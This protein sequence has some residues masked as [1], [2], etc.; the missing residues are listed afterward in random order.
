MA[1][2]APDS[3][4]S[5][6]GRDKSLRGDRE[7]RLLDLRFYGEIAGVYDSGVTPAASSASGQPAG[8]AADYGIESGAGLSASRRWRHARLTVEYRGRF[9][10]Y[11]RSSPFNGSDQFLDLAY[12]QLLNRYWT[13]NL[14]EIA[15]TTTLANGAF[16]YLP[17]SSTD[18][19]AVPSN[20]LFDNRTN[21]LQSRVDLEWQKSLRLSL[22][23]DGEGF[24]VRRQ[25]LALAGL[26]GY[27]ARAGLAYRLTR[28]QTISATYQHIYFDFQRAFGDARIETAAL[29]YSVALTRRL[30]LALNFGGSRAGVMGLMPVVIAPEIAA[31]IGNNS[32]LVSFTRVLYVPLAEARLARSFTRSSLI[33][34]Y[35]R[36][37]TPGN[38]VYLTSRQTSGTV[39]FTY[40]G[41]HRVSTA[42]S[43]SYHQLSSIGQTLPAYTNLQGGGGLT[44]RLFRETYL[45]LRYDYRH[46]NTHD[47]LLQKDSNRISLG[48]AF[49]PGDAPLAIW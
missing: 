10:D 14:K 8:A 43:A 13:L 21:Y 27:G 32:A 7:G 12:S 20:D 22:D 11:A 48:L 40:T 38:G 47:L 49:S 6:L 35:S 30:D 1:E 29:G 5:V 34:D 45:A 18:L 39:A 46:Y 9:R 25:S 28:R 2:R 33:L 3:G 24:V 36:G 17:L 44:Y 37:I 41:A 42:L 26:N 16:T 4:P 31:I 15:G 19:Y 23:F